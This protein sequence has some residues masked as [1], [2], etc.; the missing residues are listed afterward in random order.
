MV[1]LIQKEYRAAPDL[2]P[3]VDEAATL[4]QNF[5]RCDLVKAPRGEIVRVLGH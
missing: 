2:L 3:L 1:N 4:I 5:G